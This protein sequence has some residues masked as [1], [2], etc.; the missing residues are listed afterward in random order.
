MSPFIVTSK[1]VTAVRMLTLLTALAVTTACE[2]KTEAPPFDLVKLQS[3]AQALTE[4]L[5]RIHLKLD[6]AAREISE[7]ETAIAEGNNSGAAFHTTEAYRAVTKADDELIELGRALQRA[8]SL[9]I[10]KEP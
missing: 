6:T 2:R 1:T 3:Q 4:D 8:V 5:Y 9:D 7:A 10:K